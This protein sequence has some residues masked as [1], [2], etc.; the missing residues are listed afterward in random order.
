MCAVISACYALFCSLLSQVMAFNTYCPYPD[1]G[2]FLSCFNGL[3]GC[4]SSTYMEIRRT[5]DHA[6]L[7]LQIGSSY[8]SVNPRGDGTFDLS[9]KRC[10]VKSIA[11]SRSVE[12][13]RA[14]V[15]WAA[16]G[17]PNISTDQETVIALVG[18]PL[19]QVGPCPHS[20]WA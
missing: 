1:G 14:L 7:M 17:T 18:H 10:P 15:V 4:I 12:M 16:S 3:A 9:F 19:S 20:Y 2:A 6:G 5:Y 8:R 13:L 11:P